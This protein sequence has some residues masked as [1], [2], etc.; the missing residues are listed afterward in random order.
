MAETILSS[1]SRTVVIG[2]DR[3]FTIIGERINPTGRKL[4]ARE[5]AAGNYVVMATRNGTIKRTALM[6][7]ANIRT[8]GIR[9]IDALRCS[10][11]IS[12][13]ISEGDTAFTVTPSFARRAA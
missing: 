1:H 13:S 9:A 6:D 2:D 7:F 5:M 12:V 10:A 3:P 11:S 4:L 8:T